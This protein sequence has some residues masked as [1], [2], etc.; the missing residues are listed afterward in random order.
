MKILLILLKIGSQAKSVVGIAFI[1]AVLEKAGYQ[2]ELLEIEKEDDIDKIIPFVESYQ[3]RVIGLSANSHQYIYAIQIAR[4][5]KRNFN[6]PLF[7]G[8]VHATIRPEEAISEKSFDGICLGEGEEPFLELV[9]KIKKKQD[10]TGINNF[11]FRTNKRIIKNGIGHLLENLDQLPF[12]DYSIFNYFKKAGGK[13]IVPRLIFSRGCPFN[14]AYCCN[15]VFKKIYAGRGEYLRFR[16][17]DKA[18]E[19]IGLT[20]EKYNFNHFK[21]DDDTFSLNKKW[22]LEFCEKYPEKFKM[23]FECNVRPGTV[24]E[25]ILRALKMAGCSLIK[26]GV[27]AGNETLRNKILNRNISNQDIISLFSLAKK[28]GL[29]TFSFNMIGIPGETKETI[30]ETVDLNA[31]IRPDFMQVTA[32]YPYPGTIL[33]EECVRKGLIAKKHI[34]NYMEDSV[35]KLPGLTSREIKKAVSNFEYNVYRQ[36]NIKRAIQEKMR[37]IKKF[38]ISTPL[39]YKIGKPIYRLIKQL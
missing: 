35:L 39:L 26:V 19:E 29:Q 18:I 31:K 13:E 15:H 10:Y 2:V 21:I 33:G 22:V 36:Y 23:S 32:F 1:S 30:K 28:I 16:S 34:D 25:K 5:I 14:C 24:D 37:N 20:K 4:A 7:L 6:I 3:P 12:P 9:R 27:E 17:V 11:W 38:I 8:G